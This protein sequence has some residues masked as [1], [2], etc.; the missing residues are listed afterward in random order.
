MVSE[1]FGYV[2]QRK[3]GCNFN[4]GVRNEERGLT[5][6]VHHPRFDMDEAA[7]PI[8][9]E[10]MVPMIPPKTPASSPTSAPSAAVT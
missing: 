3:P 8:G 5:W 6:P 9:I 4:L 10:M 2:L 1:D 7:L